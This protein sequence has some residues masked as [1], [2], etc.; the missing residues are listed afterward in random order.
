MTYKLHIKWQ[1]CRRR[2]NSRRRIWRLDFRRQPFEAFSTKS[3]SSSQG[4]L[5]PGLDTTAPG[6]S[7]GSN[8][9]LDH[10]AFPQM[11]VFHLHAPHLRAG[12]HHLLSGG[13][14]HR[15]VTDVPAIRYGRKDRLQCSSAHVFICV[16]A[17]STF[18]I[19]SFLCLLSSQHDT[20]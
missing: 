19:S 4:S 18:I 17:A 2:R 11:E 10:G 16:S 9:G 5:V 13:W 15:C 6:A 20:T 3:V 12:D 8:L 14:Q 1:K 7:G